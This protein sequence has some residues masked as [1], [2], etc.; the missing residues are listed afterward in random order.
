MVPTASAI[1]LPQSIPLK[2]GALIEPLSVAWHAVKTSPFT[3]GSTALVL[4]GGP[5]G[6]ATILALRAHKASKIIVSEVSSQR[7]EFALKFGADVVLDPT[8]GDIVPKVKEICGEAGGVDVAFDAAGV[9]SGFDAAVLS[10]KSRGC[11]VNIAVWEK[12]VNFF[13]NDF[14]FRERRYMGVATFVEQDFKDVIDAI[15]KG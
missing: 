11:L 13:P 12:R 9:Q 10:I 2:I 7:K 1:P 6:L 15:D 4:G 14:V 8:Q 5:I 3:P